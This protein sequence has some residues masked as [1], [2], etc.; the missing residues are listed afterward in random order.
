M[1]VGIG[2]LLGL[3]GIRLPR[4]IK[5]LLV[6]KS[7]YCISAPTFYFYDMKQGIFI[8]LISF[9]GACTQS[10]YQQLPLSEHERE[11]LLLQLAVYLDDRPENISGD[12]RFD[13]AHRAYY[14]KLVKLNEAS[15][16]Q[17]VAKG[18]TIYFMYKKRD[19]RSLYEHYRFIGGKMKM[20]K[21]AE[22]GYL[23]ILFHTPRLSADELD[24][25]MF[26]F[27]KMLAGESLE[28]MHGDMKYI[29]WPDA[30]YNYDPALRR[31]KLNPQSKLNEIDYFREKKAD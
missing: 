13:T 24:K 20:T 28:A 16:V 30:D 23:D 6:H 7:E 5:S 31:W 26:L 11:A 4:F 22:I 19:R 10:G 12:A 1:Q 3:N 9:L 17:L 18:D 14:A 29:E 2:V 21:T 27:D 25:G 15:I 8:I